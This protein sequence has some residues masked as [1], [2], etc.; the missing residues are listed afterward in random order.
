[1]NERHYLEPP[2]PYD[3]SAENELADRFETDADAWRKGE[4]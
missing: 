2:E 4:R 1:M 3:E